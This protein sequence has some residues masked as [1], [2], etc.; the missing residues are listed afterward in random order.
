MFIPRDSSDKPQC[1]LTAHCS[2]RICLLSL[3]Y[4]LTSDSLFVHCSEPL[5]T[6]KQMN[7][8]HKKKAYEMAYLIKKDTCMLKLG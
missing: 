6:T 2:E 4:L 1:L 8:E 7:I 3:A 5:P